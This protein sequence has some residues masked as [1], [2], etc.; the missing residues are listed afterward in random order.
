MITSIKSIG[1]VYLVGGGPGDPELI[2]LKGAETLRRC[3]VVIY[4]ALVNPELLRHVPAHAEKIY[5]GES[6]SKRRLT[7]SQ[8]QQLMI[9]KAREGRTVVRL[10]G[11]DPFIF[12]RG[13]EEAEALQA[14]AIPWEVVPG[15]SA[16]HAVPAFA[17][18][19]LTHRHHAASVAFITGH[20]T[21][22]KENPVDWQQ[23]AR[24][25]DTLVIFMGVGNLP[26]IVENLLIAGKSPHT[27]VAV[28]E[29]GTTPRQRTRVATLATIVGS[30]TEPPVRTPAL[31]VVGEVVRLRSRLGWFAEMMSVVS[32]SA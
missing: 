28:I 14:A 16:G 29:E 6:R 25:I 12:G 20:E 32:H 2:T 19:P 11:G 8:V 7:Q 1:K 18:I 9:R 5:I 17:G 22:G 4:D 30:A 3:D 27:P 10:K 21:T 13:G 31:I 26:R 23:I 15:I 24:S